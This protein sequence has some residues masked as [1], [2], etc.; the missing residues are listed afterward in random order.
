VTDVIDQPRI[1]PRFLQ[2]WVEVRRAEGRKRLRALVVLAVVLASGAMALGALYTP[3]LKVRHVRVSVSGAVSGPQVEALAGLDHYKLM[4][5]VH[6]ATIVKDLDAVPRLGGARVDRE[7]PGTVAIRISVRTPLAIVARS[8]GGWGTVDAT[9]R[10]IGDVAAPVVGLPVLLG[11]GTAPAVGSWIGGSLGPSVIPGTVPETAL[12]M[13]AASDSATIP[14]GAAAALAL[15]QALP[16]NVFADV[17]SVTVS[18]SGGLSMAVLPASV[19]SGSI[20]VDFGDGSQL[21]QK[22]AALSTLVTQ[23]DLSGV[24]SIDLTVPDRPA[25]L[26]AR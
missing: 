18:A 7:W 21:A 26:T 15:L 23:A 3:V 22:A 11:T 4:I 16:A 14:K 25:T 19:A 24:A 12:D 2:R 8:A 20:A 10:V 5:D 6:A 17:I 9:G 1:D 13:D